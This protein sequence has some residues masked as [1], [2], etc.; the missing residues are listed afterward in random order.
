VRFRKEVCS[1]GYHQRNGD[2]TLLCKHQSGK[3]VILIVYVDDIVIT[4]TSNDDDGISCL[5]LK[6]CWLTP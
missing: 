1:Q 5:K 3:I 6:G 2:H 4:V